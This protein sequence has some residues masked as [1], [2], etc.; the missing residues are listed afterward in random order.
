MMNVRLLAVGPVVDHWLE[1]YERHAGE[2]AKLATIATTAQLRKQYD[3][4]SKVWADL[5]RTR[6]AHIAYQDSAMMEKRER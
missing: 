5:A 3:E 4:L 6:C 2:C 1:E